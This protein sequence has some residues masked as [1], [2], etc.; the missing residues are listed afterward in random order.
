[1]EKDTVQDKN[2]NI[3]AEDGGC[4][5]APRALDNPPIWSVRQFHSLELDSLETSH[6]FQ[7]VEVDIL[8]ST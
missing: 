6:D 1:M 2:Q 3:V 5:H 7:I 4:N 8:A